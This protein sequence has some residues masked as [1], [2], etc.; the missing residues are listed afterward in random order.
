VSIDPDTTLKAK[1]QDGTKV[2]KCKEWLKTFL[3][4]YAYPSDELLAAAKVAGYT[5]DNLKEAKAELKRE[6]VIYHSNAT[7]PGGWW[8]GPGIPAGWT[9]RPE[10]TPHTPHTPLSPPSP[11]SPQRE[12][13][14]GESGERGERGGDGRNAPDDA[15][16]SE[17][18]L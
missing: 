6:G 15:I 12:E 18:V 17:G 2:A 1:K 4:K 8:S 14:T 13:I 11:L 16:D 7:F 5:F 10:P 9:S 3:A